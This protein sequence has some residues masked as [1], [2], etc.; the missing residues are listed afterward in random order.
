[1]PYTSSSAAPTPATRNPTGA[2]KV[3]NTVTALQS[4]IDGQIN[5]AIPST[6]A[7][8]KQMN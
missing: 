3:P 1:M 4:Q 2:R 8:I 7:L 6:N 5:S